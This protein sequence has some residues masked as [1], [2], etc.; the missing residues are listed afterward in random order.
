MEGGRREVLGRGKGMYD[1]RIHFRQRFPII[2]FVN[3][4]FLSFYMDHF[5]Y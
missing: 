5:R 2:L 1:V 3:F 4:M